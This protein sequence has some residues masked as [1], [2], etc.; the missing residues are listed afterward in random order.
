M[1]DPWAWTWRSFFGY[2]LEYILLCLLTVLKITWFILKLSYKNVS[3]D[4]V[5][6]SF[7]KL[8]VRYNRK[9]FNCFITILLRINPFLI[10]IE[11]PWA[12][13]NVLNL[14]LQIFNTLRVYWVTFMTKHRM[15]IVAR[16]KN[17]FEARIVVVRWI[18]N[19]TNLWL[20]IIVPINAKKTSI[21]I[22]S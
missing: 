18:T 19:N 17:Y 22:F 9:A 14:L 2:M 3:I 21:W 10:D 12:L 4:P 15:Y 20:I 13:P 11:N 7:I 5:R 1:F 16:D 6:L 8:F